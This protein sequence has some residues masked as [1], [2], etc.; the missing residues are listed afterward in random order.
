MK[1]ADIS[2]FLTKLR[3]LIPTLPGIPF[4][5]IDGSE[6]FVKPIHKFARVTLRAR[7]TYEYPTNIAFDHALALRD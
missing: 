1:R 4:R 2:Q 7:V 6:N 5:V 3:G